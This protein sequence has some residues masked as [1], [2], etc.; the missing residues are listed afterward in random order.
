M[1]HIRFQ[2]ILN[3]PRI[4][5]L[6]TALQ[7]PLIFQSNLQFTVKVISV[8]DFDVKARISFCYV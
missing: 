7:I 8:S 6:K 3:D 1:Q 2:N 5:I 4:N